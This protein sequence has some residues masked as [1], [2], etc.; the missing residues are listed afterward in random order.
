MSRYHPRWDISPILAAAEHWKDQ[1]LLAHRSVFVDEAIWTDEN[2]ASL[3]RYYVENL[4]EGDENFMTKFAGQMA[5]AP[6]PAKQLAAEMM[7]F[8]LLCPSNIGPDNKRDTFYTIWDWSGVARPS[9]KPWL[10]DAVLRGI[11]SAGTAFNTHRWREVVFFVRLLQ[12]FRAESQNRQQSMVSD[13]WKMAEWMENVPEVDARQLRHMILYLLFPDTFDRIFGRTERRHLLFAFTEM[14]KQEIS[15]LTALEVSRAIQDVR[16]EQEAKFPS[17]DL[18]FY[19]SPLRNVWQDQDLLK[20]NGTPDETF[21]SYTEEV[22][23]EH[24]ELALADIDRDGYPPDARSS[25]YD[26]IKGAKRYPPKYVLSLACKHANGKEFPRQFFKGGYESQA[27]KLLKSLGFHIELKTFLRELI[28][29][30]IE[31]A[32]QETNLVVSEYPKEYRGL[33]VNVSFGKGN[34]ARIPWISFTAYDQTTQNGV[35]PV[36]L[37]YKSTSRLIVAYGISETNRP[38]ASWQDLG[39]AQ[40]ISAY[41]ADKNLTAPERYGKS[42]VYESFDLSEGINGEAIE[43]AIDELIGIYHLQF[44]GVRTPT[45]KIQP[46]EPYGLAEALSGLFIEEKKLAK[47]LALLRQKKNLILQGPPGVGKTF[48]AKRLAYALI[49]EKSNDRLAMVQFH[50]SYAYEDFIQGYR[51]SGTGFHLKNGV[52]Y[53]FCEKA[54]TDPAEHYVFIID[55]INRGNL[56]KVFGELMLLIE[57]DK[58]GPDWAIPLTYSEDSEDKFY[59]PENL[60][61]IGLMNTA[62]RSLAMVD[63]ALRRR[64]AFADLTPGFDTDEFREFLRDK[65]AETDFIEELISRIGEVNEKITNDTTNL[66]K[67][68]CIGHSFFCGIPDG[69]SPDWVWFRQVIESEIAPLLRE[70]YFDDQKQADSLVQGLTRDV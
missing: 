59:I 21:S 70:Y 58:R 1:A 15:K 4:D 47:I 39:N 48:V 51:P 64:F 23:A 3:N 60:Y 12:Q 45:A 62:D 46:K 43:A 5:D 66:G 29:K 2:I 37:Y 26:L 65:G 57:A 49:G 54:K 63:Y 17:A 11:G 31:Q 68:Y 30:F 69:V 16:R 14:S 50:Q 61:L 44:R 27:F 13:G 20:T 36:V 25:T 10:V 22:T 53:E 52:F 8:M 7:W 24:V 67:G 33:H 9:E 6:K 34:F 35:Y 41:F 38:K 28:S 40:T 19:T 18:D 55:E 32:D 42:Y 56:S